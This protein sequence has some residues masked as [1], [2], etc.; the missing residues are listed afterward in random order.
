MNKRRLEDILAAHA[1][2]LAEVSPPAAETDAEL[3]ALLD[4]AEQIKSMLTPIAPS[5]DFE[6]ELKRQLLTTAHL[7]QAQGYVPP[8]PERDLLILTAFIGA[9]IGLVSLWVILRRR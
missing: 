4:V 2:G 3:A 5:A 1:D 7:R 9:T 8:N 6:T